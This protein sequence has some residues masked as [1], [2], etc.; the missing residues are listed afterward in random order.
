FRIK[1]YEYYTDKIGSLEDLWK[2]LGTPARIKT[3]EV[4]VS[5]QEK[6][7]DEKSIPEIYEQVI[8]ANSDIKDEEEVELK[9]DKIIR[10]FNLSKS[11]TYLMTENEPIG[12]DYIIKIHESEKDGYLLQC[13]NTGH[14]NK[15]VISALLKKKLDKEYMNGLNTNDE[16]S[17]IFVIQKDEILGMVFLENGEMNFKA[18]L[19]ENIPKRDLLHLQGYKGMYKSIDQIGYVI[20]PIELFDKINRLVYKSFTSSGKALTNKNY[21]DEWKELEDYLK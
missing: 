19:T 15:V 9:E 20:I 11:G 12:S 16:I 13:Y 18:H 5:E 10:Y 2:I 4:T 7:Q 14:I 8:V 17:E 1:G 3:Q 21:A 6:V